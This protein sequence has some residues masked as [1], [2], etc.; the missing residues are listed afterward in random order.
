MLVN[1]LNKN[2]ELH[3]SQNMF[4]SVP[5]FTITLINFFNKLNSHL[6]A[7]T[8]TP[9]KACKAEIQLICAIL[10]SVSIIADPDMERFSQTLQVQC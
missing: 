7:A 3:S 10:V 8:L 9:T 4:P 2:K 1:A 6:F 5:T